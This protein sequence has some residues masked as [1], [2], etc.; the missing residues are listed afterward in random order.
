MISGLPD[1]NY[2]SEFYAGIPV[3]RFVAWVADEILILLATFIVVLLTL[4]L[5]S[6]FVTIIYF[7]LSFIYRATTLARRSATLGMRL[8][9]IE[10]RN[11]RG[12]RLDQ[13][14]AMLHVGGYMISAVFLL[15]L[16]ISAFLVI[17]SSRC[18]ALH[19]LLFGTAAI[20][21]PG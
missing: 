14:E 15:P 5:A 4:G 7:T 11:I 2:Q 6:F 21:R 10:I 8:M 18:Q 12:Q 17:T 1:P 3:K 16:V 20:N 9:A 19:D 13:G